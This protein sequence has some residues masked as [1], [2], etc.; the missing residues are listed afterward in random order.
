MSEFRPVTTIHDLF[1]LDDAEIEAGYWAGRRGDPEPGNQS[2]RA[3]WH[4]WRNGR[5]DAGKRKPDKGQVRLRCVL[6]SNAIAGSQF[7]Q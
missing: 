3:Y 5:V 2:S 1:L 7:L 4:G 6:L